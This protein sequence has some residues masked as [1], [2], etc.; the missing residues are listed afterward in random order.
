M[1]EQIRAEAGPVIPV[2]E[3]KYRDDNTTHPFRVCLDTV[4]L[5]SLLRADFGLND[6]QIQRS[7]FIVA[8]EVVT[9]EITFKSGTEGTFVSEIHTL[10]TTESGGDKDDYRIITVNLG[11]ILWQTDY[12]NS[13]ALQYCVLSKQQ[14]LPPSYQIDKRNAEAVISNGFRTKRMLRY[15]QQVDWHR[16]IS[17]LDRMTARKIAHNVS[18][19][20]V[21]ETSHL[22]DLDE[23]EEARLEF[24]KE[25]KRGIVSIG[26]CVVGAT[27]YFGL[28]VADVPSAYLLIPFSLALGFVGAS[29][30]SNRKMKRNLERQTKLHTSTEEKAITAQENANISRWEK[31]IRLEPNPNYSLTP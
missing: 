2:V 15:L 14:D 22:K 19:V 20:L 23:I 31:I 16:A 18:S 24:E 4:K 10:G 26:G 30:L 3:Y 17:F 29:T 25:K 7:K 27:G 1:I 5:G 8:D 12:T 28:L 9:G 13:I 21:H 11:S 6:R